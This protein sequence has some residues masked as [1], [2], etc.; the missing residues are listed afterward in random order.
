MR[1]EKIKDKASRKWEEK[2]S[3]AERKN[4]EDVV[5]GA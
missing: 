5:G 2:Y 1:N 3:E 4:E